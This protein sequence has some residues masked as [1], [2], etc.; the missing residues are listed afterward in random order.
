MK[1]EFARSHD[2]RIRRG[3]WNCMHLKGETCNPTGL[4]C[5]KDGE[6]NISTTVC[7]AICDAWS[8]GGDEV[9]DKNRVS[10]N[11]V[12]P[13]RSERKT[14]LTCAMCDGDERGPFMSMPKGKFICYDCIDLILSLRS[15][16]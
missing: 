9:M 11:K 8:D 14:K 7:F 2:Y 16:K 3:C 13:I 5:I 1:K 10:Y 4:Y 15:K 6:E 12:Y